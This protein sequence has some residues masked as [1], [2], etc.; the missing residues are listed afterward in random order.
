MPPLEAMACGVPVVCS[1]E[2]SL[3]EV[4]GDCAVMTDAYDP[5]SIADGMYRIYSDK[6]LAEEL[7]VRGLQR[8]KEFTWHRFSEKLHGIYEAVLK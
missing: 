6:A 7:R 3:P 4:V 8:A 2:A 5:Q 1:K